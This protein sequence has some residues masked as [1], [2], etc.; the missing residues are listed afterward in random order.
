MRPGATTT[1]AAAPPRPRRLSWAHLLRRLLD[2][3]ALSCPRCRTP[4][5][6]LAFLTDPPVVRRILEHLR[7]PAA[8]PHL[9]PA[10]LPTDEPDFFTDDL[11]LAPFSRPRSPL[12]RAPP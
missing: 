1:P 11:P 7:L 2:V 6:V 12:A 5:V 10:R 3:D 8:P 9:A 4:I